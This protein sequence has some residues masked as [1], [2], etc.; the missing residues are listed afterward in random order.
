MDLHVF[1]HNCENK[2]I[3]GPLVFRVSNSLIKRGI[4]SEILS[5]STSVTISKCDF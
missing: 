5:L 1:N 2:Y 4:R 3:M